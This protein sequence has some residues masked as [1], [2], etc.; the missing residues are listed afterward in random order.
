M[1]NR[2]LCTCI[3]SNFS[4]I[5]ISKDN[6]KGVVKKYMYPEMVKNVVSNRKNTILNMFIGMYFTSRKT[7]WKSYTS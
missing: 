6:L 3:N 1:D 7:M 4:F 2:F 5:D